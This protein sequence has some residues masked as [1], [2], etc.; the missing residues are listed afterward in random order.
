MDRIDIHIDVPRVDFEKLA[1]KRDAERSAEIRKRVE[2]ARK[3][4]NERLKES[5]LQCNA[6]MGPS[7]VRD[8]CALDA[9]GEQLMKSAMAQMNLSAR[10]YHRILK[11]GRTIADLSG[12][13]TIQPNHLA[14]ALQYRPRQ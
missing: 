14:E 3:I 1:S 6:D 9:T 2:A 4:Q 13:P 5:D 11:L 12:E 8:M 10:A 7:E